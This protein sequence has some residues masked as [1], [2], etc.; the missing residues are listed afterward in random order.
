MRQWPV[1]TQQ[2]ITRHLLRFGLDIASGA[3]ELQFRQAVEVKAVE[4]VKLLLNEGRLRL[5]AL[6]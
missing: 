5:H 2:R 4:L 3:A 1:R 6:F